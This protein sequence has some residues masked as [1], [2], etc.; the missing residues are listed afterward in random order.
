[1]SSVPCFVIPTASL[2][3][4]LVVPA[5]QAGTSAAAHS[6]HHRVVAP[7][8]RAVEPLVHA[9]EAAQPARVRRVGVV[10]DAVLERERA[11][12]RRFPQSRRRVRAKDGKSLW[13]AEL[14]AG[15]H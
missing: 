1:M 11:H 14:A 6:A 4:V 12:A 2:A 5:E 9:P 8:W 7:A 3:V 15:I 13:V 10:G